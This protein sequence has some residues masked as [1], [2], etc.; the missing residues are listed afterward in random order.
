MRITECH[1]IFYITTSVWHLHDCAGYCYYRHR[2]LIV[3][4]TVQAVLRIIE[5]AII[6]RL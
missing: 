4:D 6:F 5:N 3:F 2:Y 1:L